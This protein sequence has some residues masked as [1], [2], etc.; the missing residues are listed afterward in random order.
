MA[1]K[2]IQ[3]LNR[4]YI[5]KVL[6]ENDWDYK[7]SSHETQVFYKC[8]NEILS[9]I[10]RRKNKL[11]I[12]AMPMFVEK[13]CLKEGLNHIQIAN[14]IGNVGSF[15]SSNVYQTLSEGIMHYD[16]R[17]QVGKKNIVTYEISYI[18][19]SE[20]NL[21]VLLMNP[22]YT[23]PAEL[24]VAPETKIITIWAFLTK[25]R[26]I[27]IHNIY[28]LSDEVRTVHYRATEKS[29]RSAK[30]DI[31]NM[32]RLFYPYTYSPPVEICGGCSRRSECPI[33]LTSP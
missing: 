19:T 6:E 14:I 31:N 33:F 21:K 22:N 18:E 17:L 4:S 29:Y 26:Y 32:E 20:D 15:L 2:S 27:D 11:S 24:A 12:V 23:T 8:I 3:Q 30:K 1:I 9:W 5:C 10:A 25:S 7:S 16:V 13:I 28:P